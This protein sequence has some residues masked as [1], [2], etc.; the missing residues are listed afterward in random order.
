MP[1]HIPVRYS[2]LMLLIGLACAAGMVFLLN[3]LLSGPKLG[4]HYDLLLKL[5]KPAAAAR[6]ILI[7]NT[8]EFAE[9]T[10]VFTV[11]MTLTEMSAD[12]LVMTGKVSHFSSPVMLTET[13]I[14]RRFFDEYNLVGAN[15][16]NLFEGI[17]MGSVSP[18][19]A[20]S[21]VDQLVEL[22]VKGRDRLLATLVDRD[23]DLVRSAYAFGSYLEVE[24]EPLFDWGGVIRRVKLF[25]TGDYSQET[26]A[27]MPAHP[28]YLNLIDRYVAS[29]VENTEHGQVLWLR[30]FDGEEISLPLDKDGNVI[31][32][33]NCNFR[34]TD[35]SVFREYEA[36]DYSMLNV[37]AAADELGIFSDLL[38]E[39]REFEMSPFFLGDYSFVLKEELLR[40]PN[41][42]NRTA[43]K[44]ARANYLKSLDDIFSGSFFSEIILKYEELF[45][46][47][48]PLDDDKLIELTELREKLDEM[49]LLLRGD[50]KTFHDLYALLEDELMFSYC[51]IGP[52]DN[53]LYSALVANVLMTGAHVN[54]ADDQFVIILS[55]AVSAVV[56]L[57]VFLFRPLF[58]LFA[59]IFFSVLA[60][61]VFS[62]FFIF[63]SY[64]IDPVIILGS[65]F[66]GMMVIFYCKC[67]LLDYR[68]RTFR[69]A[70]GAV[71]SKQ[72]L[73][74]LI[75]SGKPRLSDVNVTNA[76]ILAIKETNLLGKEDREKTQD[77]GKVRSAFLSSVKKVIFSAGAVI[78]GFEG[79]TILACFGS[80]LESHPRLATCKTANDG[81][82]L[83]KSYN[84][85]DK[86]CALVKGLLEIEKNT[87][88]FGLDAGECTFY[89][90][91]E[92]GYSV[93]GRPAVRARIL[94]S[95]TS[96]FKVRALITDTIRKK[97]E[98]EGT[99]LGTLYNKDDA[100]FSLD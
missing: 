22:T 8:D 20:P 94:V 89:W 45:D 78:V 81:E 64:W 52:P 10:D 21:Y 57:I 24:T 29:Q 85:V 53:A 59:S 63:Y 5:K 40:A 73:Q 66:T 13:E 48:D 11:L 98:I 61:A 99:Q 41:H 60:A 47:A 6:E 100:F 2:L 79:D 72:Y 49:I 23:E 75:T 70:Y 33:W 31:T 65:S 80:P 56:L 95:K 92:T 97:M 7:I 96:R 55:I 42:E 84:P 88:R 38:P 28:V 43:W 83:V 39:H 34:K 67:A 50:Y 36:A 62:F 69:A 71:V 19:Q 17:R 68:S 15:I 12:N 30:K 27:Q 4:P 82:T 32:P 9:G 25:D 46:A 86:A 3:S 77:A 58:L 26:Q 90:S 37:L 44:T 51:I 14:R 35:I 93:K 74:N 91:P 16:R 76:A 18:V 1:A 87:W 54:Y